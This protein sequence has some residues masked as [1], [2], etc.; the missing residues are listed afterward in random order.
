M[1]SG[2]DNSFKNDQTKDVMD[3]CSV[4]YVFVVHVNRLHLYCVTAMHSGTHSK[5]TKQKMSWIVVLLFM[6]LLFM[7]I[8]YISIVSQQCILGLIQKSPNKRCHG[9]LFFWLVLFDWVNSP[10]MHC[11]GTIAIQ[12]MEKGYGYG[13]KEVPYVQQMSRGWP[14]GY[15]NSPGYVNRPDLLN[16]QYI[17]QF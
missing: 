2:T 14:G 16:I 5:I 7:S 11:C 15:V 8:D 10:R 4:V 9:L 17:W 13:G 6:F 3:C 12:S 1:H